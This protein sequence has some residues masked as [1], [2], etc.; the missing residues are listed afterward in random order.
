MELVKSIKRN[1]R[2]SGKG[3]TWIVEVE[4]P[5][6]WG[7]IDAK[8][9]GVVATSE[10]I[11]SIRMNWIRGDRVDGHPADFQGAE[12]R[13]RREIEQFVIET[14]PDFDTYHEFVTKKI[15]SEVIDK[16]MKRQERKRQK[17]WQKYRP[18]WY[19][20]ADFKRRIFKNYRMSI[21]SGEVG[22]KSV[23]AQY[24]PTPARPALYGS[25]GMVDT[26]RGKMKPGRKAEINGKMVTINQGI[27]LRVPKNRQ[28]T[29]GWIG[30][31]TQPSMDRLTSSFRHMPET[32]AALEQSIRW[33]NL[34]QTATNVFAIMRLTYLV[35]RT[36]S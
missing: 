2:G 17:Y 18:N 33:Q 5:A 7:D 19:A 32:R 24:S 27:E 35:A 36:L 22:K 29:A 30:G 4:T 28:K 3:F 23:R 8:K 1:S 13:R 16:S 21:P 25:G 26:L 15:E 6:V 20:F 14:N 31:L 12:Q 34:Q 10:V 9:Y 11:N